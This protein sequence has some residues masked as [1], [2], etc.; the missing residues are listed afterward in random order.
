MRSVNNVV[1]VTNYVM[2]ELGQPLHAF[3]LDDA[4][5]AARSSSAA[6]AR[7]RRSRRSTA[8]RARSTPEH[9]VIADARPLDRASP[10]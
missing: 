8:R 2:L 10:A 3:D 5:R 7:A 9:L 4:R 6:P 1:D